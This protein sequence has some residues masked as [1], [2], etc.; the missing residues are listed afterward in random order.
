MKKFI[1]NRLVLACINLL[2]AAM[3][4]AAA[5]VDMASNYPQHGVQVVQQV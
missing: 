3:R 1:N 5:L 2:S 4:L